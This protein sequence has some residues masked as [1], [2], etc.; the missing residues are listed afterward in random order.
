MLAC[1][2]ENQWVRPIGTIEFVPGHTISLPVPTTAPPFPPPKS[3]RAPAWLFG[4][5]LELV[6]VGWLKEKHVPERDSEEKLSVAHSRLLIK[7]AR[8][9]VL[10]LLGAAIETVRN[11][12]T[13]AAGAIPADTVTAQV[14]EANKRPKHWLKGIEGLG[15]K[16]MD[17][18]SY[19][20][21]L[22]EKQQLAFSL[23]F[24]YGLGL[25]E[26]ASRMG[27]DRKTAHEHIEAADRKVSQ[28]RSN[29]RGKAQRAKNTHE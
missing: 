10:R 28:A 18:S 12:E 23:K 24:E 6:G 17:L 13:A 22:T 1:D 11:E 4:I 26:V 21:D 27:L 3:W 14:G 15:P 7:G 5:S 19:M 8:R 2:G 25:A 29:E 20:D 9:V 16:T